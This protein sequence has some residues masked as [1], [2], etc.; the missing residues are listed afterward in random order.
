M[1][2]SSHGTCGGPERLCQTRSHGSSGAAAAC[3]SAAVSCSWAV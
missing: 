1:S 3:T 2:G